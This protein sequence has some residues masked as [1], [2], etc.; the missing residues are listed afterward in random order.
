MDCWCP[1]L[2]VSVDIFKQKL[3]VMF[4]FGR[5]LRKHEC[6]RKVELGL[7]TKLLELNS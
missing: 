6:F 5:Q 7:R 2:A 4:E 1:L 3:D